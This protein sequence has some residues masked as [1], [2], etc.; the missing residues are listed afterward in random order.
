MYDIKDIIKSNIDYSLSNK[1]Y[2]KDIDKYVLDGEI[3][4]LNKKLT[5]TK[6]Y[7]VLESIVSHLGIH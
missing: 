2:I 1:F 3:V 7:K 5:N 4:T 6:D